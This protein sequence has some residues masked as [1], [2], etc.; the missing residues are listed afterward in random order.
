[1]QLSTSIT[2]RGEDV[3]EGVSNR[4]GTGTAGD[5]PGM[6]R[7][8]GKFELIVNSRAADP[9]TNCQRLLALLAIRGS[10]VSRASAAGI[11]WPEATVSRAN[12]NLRSVLWKLQRCCADVV[13]A[14]FHV[15]RLTPDLCV[16]LQEVG[17][18]ARGLLDRSVTRTPGT[19]SGAL[20][21]N[22]YDDIVPDLGGEDWL[23]DER[24]QHRQLRLHALEAL[25]EDLIAVGWYGAAVETAQA[26]I[27]V[28][29]FRESARLLLVQAY[30]GEG[31][32]WEA[33]RQHRVYCTLMRS[34]LGLEPT[35]KFMKLGQ[36][37]DGTCSPPGRALPVQHRQPARPGRGPRRQPMRAL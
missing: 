23:A 17:R 24:E 21:C 12:A 10:Q 1:M 34:E 27:R 20:S 22:L 5:C 28:D 32:Q 31:N 36:G 18:V 37:L 26:V 2:G 6:L 14:S 30:L 4:H 29:P 33:R 35:D 3:T 15:I 16:D 9:S 25:G 19:L 7:V 11:L 8:L 13:E